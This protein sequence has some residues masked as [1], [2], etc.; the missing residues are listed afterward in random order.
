MPIDSPGAPNNSRRRATYAGWRDPTFGRY[1][2]VMPK[3]RVQS[4]WLR[5]SVLWQSR[6]DKVASWIRDGV[7]EQRRAWVKRRAARV[8][9]DF[10]LHRNEL[11]DFAFL[12]LGDT[13]E[14]DAS[15]WAVA[16]AMKSRSEDTAFMFIASDVI[17]PTGELADY[18]RKFLAP[19]D[20]YRPPVYAVPG[21]HDWYDNLQGFM[22][23]F[24]D[25]EPPAPAPIRK[26]LARVD[27]REPVRRLLWRKSPAIP[28]DGLDRYRDARRLHDPPQPGPYFAIETERLR[29]VG[30]DTG[31]A[32]AID[33]DQARWLREVSSGPKP[34]ILITGKPIVVNNAYEPSR[35]QGADETID[36]I[37]REPGHRYI[38]AFGGDIHNYQR[39]PVQVDGRTIQYVVCGGGGAFMHA[40]HTIPKVN[41]C[42]IAE[43]NFRCYPLR[44]D[45]LSFYS[46]L[47]N[48]RVGAFLG[49]TWTLE[50]DVASYLLG[51][52]YGIPA[53]RE[54]ARRIIPTEGDRRAFER[55]VGRAAGK[56]FQRY[57]SEF[58]DNNRPPFFKHFLRLEVSGARL[59]V[60]C[61][62][63]TGWPEDELD[64]P[65]EDCF[66]I[67]P[68]TLES[69]DCRAGD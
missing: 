18:E 11:G 36:D 25:E 5:P 27:P 19:Y 63:V 17:Y 4:S 57:V 21:N 34:K 1:F 22:F 23:S 49:E 53:S 42:G 65:E 31:I 35:I 28:T 67:D 29:I 46:R 58:F 51:E 45:S 61:L 54:D 48:D 69:R 14:G 13:G 24:C 8:R 9:D 3:E 10:T 30:V 52:R 68:E 41:V 37:V 50:P 62:A 6:N 66:T 43:R 2:D 26:G 39:Y 64:P 59:T 60:R 16:E 15:Q 40:T 44:G 55:V 32:N 38:A 56:G 33:A 7:I 12:V 47:Y 20:F